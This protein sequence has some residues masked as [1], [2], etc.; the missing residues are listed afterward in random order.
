MIPVQKNYPRKKQ[1]E[2]NKKVIFAK[3]E[4]E[5]FFIPKYK[6]HGDNNKG[7]PIAEDYM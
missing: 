4:M 1:I 2:H 6:K 7:R 5:F 3:F